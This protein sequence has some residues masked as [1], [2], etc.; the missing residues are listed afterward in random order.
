MFI[1]R[2]RDSRF[3]D[4]S[5]PATTNQT[6]RDYWARF[7]YTPACSFCTSQLVKFQQSRKHVEGFATGLCLVPQPFATIAWENITRSV[8][9][10]ALSQIGRSCQQAYG[11]FD[12]IALSRAN[13]RLVAPPKK[14]V[15]FLVGCPEW[16]LASVYIY[17][18]QASSSWNSQGRTRDLETIARTWNFEKLLITV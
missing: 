13:V 3:P 1:S 6:S 12:S 16:S 2:A 7:S 15:P 10:R 4:R 18:T 9:R 5:Q 17:F 14:T 11:F 8:E